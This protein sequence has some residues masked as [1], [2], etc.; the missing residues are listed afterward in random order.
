[1]KKAKVTTKICE[2]G[3]WHSGPVVTCQKCLQLSAR[4]DQTA[5][6]KIGRYWRTG[7]LSE[8]RLT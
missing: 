6:V 1:M 8:L 5:R 2:C 3:A 7:D 4:I